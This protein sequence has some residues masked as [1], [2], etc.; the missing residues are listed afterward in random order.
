MIP[1]SLV[2][3][4]DNP[5]ANMIMDCQVARTMSVM[6]HLRGKRP[7]KQ[8]HAWD[9]AV[10]LDARC[11]YCGKWMRKEGY[12]LDAFKEGEKILCTNEDCGWIFKLGK[13]K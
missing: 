11:P 1:N 13:Q 4:S 12:R 7:M 8:S 6:S 3:T 9:V 10:C 2:A 5:L